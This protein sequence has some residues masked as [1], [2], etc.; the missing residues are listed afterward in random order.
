MNSTPGGSARANGKNMRNAVTSFL[1]LVFEE[2]PLSSRPGISTFTR[3]FAN[4]HAK[5]FPDGPHKTSDSVF[6]N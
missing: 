2:F 6:D 3:N 4:T 1:L 5:S